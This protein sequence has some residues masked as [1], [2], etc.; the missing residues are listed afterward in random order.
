MKG[1]LCSPIAG[2]PAASIRSAAEPCGSRLAGD[3]PHYKV[4]LI[5]DWSKTLAKHMGQFL[6]V[7]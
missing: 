4:L 2:K 5:T 1:L 6:K 7:P 3:W